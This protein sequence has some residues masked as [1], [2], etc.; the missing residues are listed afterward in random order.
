M[1]VTSD[2]KTQLED[3]LA[4]MAEAAELDQ[5]RWNRLKSAY[6][7]ISEWLNNDPEFF[8]QVEFEI[9]PQGSVAI[10]TT[11]PKLFLMRLSVDWRRRN[12]TK[13]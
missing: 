6:E 8:R 1:L 9:Y 11:N 3:T 4:K 12:S 2:S 7:A 13:A 5:T 10:G